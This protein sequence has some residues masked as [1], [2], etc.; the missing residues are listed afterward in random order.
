M[1]DAYAAACLHRATASQRGEMIPVFLAKPPASKAFHFVS[2]KCSGI[3]P[4][5]A[6]RL[7]KNQDWAKPVRLILNG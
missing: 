2:L 3:V 7:L 5:L 6:K 1:R 4:M